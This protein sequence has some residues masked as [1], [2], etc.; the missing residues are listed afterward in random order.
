ME[1]VYITGMSGMLGQQLTRLH[2]L[3]G[4]IVFGCD[5][6]PD[7][8]H[9]GVMPIDIR[10][11]ATLSAHIK[12]SNATKLYHCAA[13]LG[14]QNTE[15]YPDVCREINEEG[16]QSVFNAARFADITHLTF[17][18]SSEVYGGSVVPLTEISPC[19]G[20]NVYAKGKLNSE[21]FLR[22]QTGEMH[23]TICRMFNCYGPHQVKQ[24]FLSK[25][26]SQAI[27]GE[28]I[29]LFGDPSNV[30]S[31][32]YAS[33]AAAHIFNVG[34][35]GLNGQVYNV[36]HPELITLAEAASTVVTISGEVTKIT[37]SSGKNG[38][39][40][41]TKERDIPNRVGNSDKLKTISDHKPMAFYDGVEKF[42]LNQ[43]SLKSDWGYARTLFNG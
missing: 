42:F 40:D 19:K 8:N 24:F 13:M 11:T 26:M 10:D 9:L 3:R 41:R 27:D 2:T 22:S 18:S 31:Y 20:T 1:I 12:M 39:T 7:V 36:S 30:R 33:D 25:I 4:D 17:L 15:R 32:L 23:I 37:T 5:I 16:T 21:D 38:Y 35:Y 28:T 43:L 29:T 14:V 6:A 34:K